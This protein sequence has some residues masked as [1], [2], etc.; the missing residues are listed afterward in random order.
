MVF[1][2]SLFTSILISI[3]IVGL[4]ILLQYLIF[5]IVYLENKNKNFLEFINFNKKNFFLFFILI[6]F[7]VYLMNPIF[8]H[9]PQEILNSVK[10]MSKYQ[11]DICT[12]TLGDCMKSLNLPSSYYFIWLFFK[13]PIFI[14]LGFLAFP[15]IEKKLSNNF[16]NK[17]F[18]YSFSISLF[19]INIIHYL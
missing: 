15:F 9:N 19:S 10:W 1:F 18:V 13:L 11:Q 16:L 14:I 5:I 8:W 12:V 17:I 2:I 7:F 6:I 4:L 3:R